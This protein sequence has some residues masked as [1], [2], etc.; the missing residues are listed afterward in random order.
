MACLTRLPC[1]PWRAIP[2][3]LADFRHP[4]STMYPRRQE[5]G[6][7]AWIW[8]SRVVFVDYDPTLGFFETRRFLLFNR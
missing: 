2:L 7:H 3:T 1:A 4:D 8:H 6:F 5:R